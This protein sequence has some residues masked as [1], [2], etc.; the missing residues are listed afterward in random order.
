MDLIFASP[1]DFRRTT[2][3]VFAAIMLGIIVG[4]SGVKMDVFG[5]GTAAPPPPT[6][7]QPV[8]STARIERATDYRMTR[9]IAGYTVTIRDIEHS[10]TETT[11][12]Y[13]VDSTNP[14]YGMIL[15]AR[16]VNPDGTVVY[17]V[18]SEGPDRMIQHADGT[19]EWVGPEPAVAFDS[20]ELR[21]G[22]VV[23]FGPFLGSEA[24]P[25]LFSATG[26]ELRAGLTVTLAGDEFY[27]TMEPG[28]P[29]DAIG[30][31]TL[32]TLT[33]TSA[34]AT[35]QVDWPAGTGLA[36]TINGQPGEVVKGGGGFNKKPG[37]E[38]G[39]TYAGSLLPAVIGDNDVVEAHAATIGRITQGDWSF[40]LD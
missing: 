14:Q 6:V 20:R 30:D 5:A 9:S 39:G 10:A 2:V 28:S 31:T 35:V 13:E 27:A 26:A 4:L 7:T 38:I 22:A 40:P 12:R 16:A 18:R 1:T 15:A 34:D 11:I 3:A 19:V 29:V 36:W 25:A 33:S 17:P 37:Y 21:P 24:T 23:K 32:V 8:A